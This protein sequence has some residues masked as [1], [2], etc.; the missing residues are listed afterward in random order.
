ML[1]FIAFYLKLFGEAMVNLYDF[2]E[3]L[4]EKD[5]RLLAIDEDYFINVL[6][7]TN[8]DFTAI[9]NYL[10]D[11]I[12]N[13]LKVNNDISVLLSNRILENF[14]VKIFGLRSE[15]LKAFFNAFRNMVQKEIYS[16]AFCATNNNEKCL[17]KIF[18]ELLEKMEIKHFKKLPDPLR[19]EAYLFLRKIHDQIK[20][21][22][23]RINLGISNKQLIFLARILKIDPREIHLNLGIMMGFP[24]LTDKLRTVAITNVDICRGILC[25]FNK[26][27]RVGVNSHMMRKMLFRYPMLSRIVYGA[28]VFHTKEGIIFIFNKRLNIG[29]ITT[30]PDIF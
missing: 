27:K 4:I 5:L 24:V 7:E 14:S 16:I 23:N 15:Q 2:F 11:I 29:L 13:K 26:P 3:S 6:R 8:Y 25:K 28:E 9:L 19:E 20:E 18:M 21:S 10:V 30:P 17:R 1:P 12:K 22:L